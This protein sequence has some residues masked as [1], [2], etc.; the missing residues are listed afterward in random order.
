MLALSDKWA[1]ILVS[2]PE[3]GMD[4]QMASVYLKDGW[5]FDRVVIVGAFL[6]KFGEESH[7]PLNDDIDGIVVNRGK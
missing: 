6:T 1:P 5:K 7:I 3:T 2:Q 4:Y